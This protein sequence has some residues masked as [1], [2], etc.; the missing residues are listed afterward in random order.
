MTNNPHFE[1]VNLTGVVY[2]T[3]KSIFAEA[4]QSQSHENEI[5]CFVIDLTLLLEDTDYSHTL[6]T[7]GHNMQ[8]ERA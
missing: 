8:G 6:W 4:F 1:N 2:V 7:C 5:I 3:A